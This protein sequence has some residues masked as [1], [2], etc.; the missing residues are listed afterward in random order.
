MRKS[1]KRPWHQLLIGSLLLLLLAFNGS[2]WLLRHAHIF[3]GRANHDPAQIQRFV[4]Q[5]IPK[6]SHVVGPP[7][8]YYAVIGAGSRYELNSWYGS[9]EDRELGHRTRWEYDYLITTHQHAREDRY[10]LQK[11]DL[12]LV[13]S[14][15][16]F[17]NPTTQTISSLRIFG[18]SLIAGSED[19]GYSCRIYRRTPTKAEE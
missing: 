8:F 11:S 5:H 7:A 15:L 9:L 3:A 4:A 10:Y 12:Q 6:G 14:L 2:Y 13:D 17:P 18:I 16:L 1:E 19:M